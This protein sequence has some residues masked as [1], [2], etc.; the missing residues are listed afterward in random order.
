MRRVLVAIAALAAIVSVTA[1]AS[2]KT[3][4]VTTATTVSFSGTLGQYDEYPDGTFYGTVFSSAKCRQD[5]TVVV[6]RAEGPVVGTTQSDHDGNWSVT[7]TTPLTPGQYDV[8]VEK[9]VI[10]KKIKHGPN[11]GKKKRTICERAGEQPR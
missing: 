6:R 1:V 11:K 4:H 2:A 10:K 8:I 9:R 3:K 7:A 5:R